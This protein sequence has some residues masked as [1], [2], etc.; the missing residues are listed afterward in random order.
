[1]N[2]FRFNRNYFIAALVIFIIEVL[3]AKYLD[4][5]IIRPY[6]GDVLVV[7]L[8]YCF[9]RA[10]FKTPIFATAIGA[11]VFAYLVE[12]LQYIRIVDN[13]GLQ[14]SRL[15]RTVLGT[16][17]EWTDIAAYTLGIGIVL[18]TENLSNRIRN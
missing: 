15:A 8:I 11:L 5:R 18:L 2:T 9:V 13:L 14:N 10:F 12:G 1:M 6:I 17:A 16:S 4:D 3:I 7:I